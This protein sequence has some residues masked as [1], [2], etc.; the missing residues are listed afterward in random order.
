MKQK[1]CDFGG[2]ACSFFVVALMG[3]LTA[4]LHASAVNEFKTL[5]SPGHSH[6]FMICMGQKPAFLS[7]RE[8]IILQTRSLSLGVPETK[9][10]L[11]LTFC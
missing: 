6:S 1:L 11:N 8:H 7:Q 5:P 9:C 10:V 4:A 2:I 3:A